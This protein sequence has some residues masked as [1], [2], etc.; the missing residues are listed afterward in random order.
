VRLNRSF[1]LLLFGIGLYASALDAQIL[2]TLSTTSNSLSAGQSATLTAVCTA[3][4]GNTGVTWSVTPSLGTLGVG[5][6]L[7]GSSITTTNNYAAP[8]VVT[9]RQTVTITAR[10]IQDPTKF[11]SVNIQLNPASIVV[12]PSTVTLNPG[13]SQQFTATGG[14]AG[15]VWSISPSTGSIDHNGVYT[16]PPTVSASTN[17][18]VTATSSADSS[19]FGTARITLTQTQTVSVAIS[20]TSVSLTQGQTQQFTATVSNASSSAVIWSFTPQA[21]TLD[22]NG[23]YTA[24]S[25]ITATSTIRVTA[26]AAADASKSASA[27][28]TLTSVIDVGSGAPTGALQNQFIGAF[29]RN[30]FANLVSLPPLGAVKRL[31]TTGYVQ[32]F[33]D[34][35]KTGAKLALATLSPSAPQGPD[36]TNSIAQL[37]ADLYA[38]YTTVGATTAGLPLYDTLNCPAFDGNSC[39][40][41]IFDKGYALFAYHSPLATGQNFTIRN[42]FYTEWTARLGITGPGRPVDVETAVTASTKTTATVQSFVNGAIYVI[43]SGVNNAKA[44][45]VLSP[46][47]DVYIATGGPA[48]SLGLPIT[49]EIT[50]S[51]G[52]HRQTFEGG[53]LEYTPG[54]GGPSQRLPVASVAIAGASTGVPVA[55]NLGDM[56]TLTAT[57]TAAN[58]SALTDRPVSWSTS[59][60]KVVSIEAAGSK[61]VLH[62]TGGG[63]AAVTATSEGVLSPKINLIVIAPCCQVGDGAPANVQRSFQDALTRNRIT[64]QIPVAGPAARVSN[65]YVQVI[66][67]SDGSTYWLAQSDQVGSAFVVGG[68]I[69]QAYDALGGPAGTLGYPLSDRSAGGTQRFENGAALAGNPVR[70]VN[71]GVLAKWALLGYEAGSAGAPT[72]DAA[73]FSTFGANAGSSQAFS[74]ATLYAASAG[75]RAGQAYSVSGAI[76]A[77]YTALGGASGNF[78]MPT[79]DEFV[80]GG[81]HQQNFEGGN[82]TWAPG[83][84]DAVEHAALKAPGVVASPPTVAAGGRARLALVGFPNASTLKVSVTGQQDFTVATTNGSYSWDM[85]FPLTTRSAVLTVTAL[86]PKSGTTA[87]GTLTI[88]GYNDNRV[89]LAR[90]Q[91]D[92]QTGAPGALLPLSLRVAVRDAA[93]DPVTGATVSFAASSGSLLAAS[94]VTDG[95]GIAETL[96]RLPAQ[97]TVTLVTAEAPGVA[98]APVTFA[99]RS[100]ATSL[101]N[102]PKLQQAGRTAIGNG[103]ATIGQ[104]GALL[105]A[106]AS[107]LRYHQNRSELPGPNGSADPAALNTFLK[108]YCAPD[109]SGKL[110]CDG[111][112]S[113][114]DSGEQVVNLWR[115]AEFTGGA[116]VEI[117]AP[118]TN[119]I[120]DLVAGG[121]PVLLSLGLSRNGAVA[122]G[123]FVVAI[124]IAAD[125]SIAIQDPSPV[126]ARVSLK[127]Y[128]GGFTANG[129]IWKAEVRGVAQFALNSP[130]AT[131]FLA[132]AISQPPGGVEP[133]A[134][135]VSS[136][137]GWCGRPIDLLDA[138]DPAAAGN[139]GLMSRILG[140]DGAQ[141]VYQLQVG[142]GQAFRAVV[143]DLAAGGAM[144]DISGA[145][146]SSY[147]LTRPKLNLT[148]AS[149]DVAVQAGGIVGAATFTPGIAPGGAASIF[150]SGLSGAGKNTMLDL[151]GTS[152]RVIFATPFQLNAEVPPGTTPGAHTLH[153]QS[154]YGTAAQTVT[155]SAVAPGIFMVGNPP[156][157]A[158]TNAAGGL[159]VP[160]NPLARGQTV[161]VWA[162]GLGAVTA[163]GNL[164]VT[165][166]T[167]T[168]VVGGVE[169]PVQFAG[170]APGFL[171]LGLYQ[172]NVLIP[173]STPPG[174]NVPFALKIEGQLSNAVSLAIQ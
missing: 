102:F 157:A 135:S 165:S 83:S 95:N 119:A 11:A 174:L 35:L 20:P 113:N 143:D 163:S 2:V 45:T 167:V 70:L 82:I 49:Q 39:T 24:P 118:T 56:L 121:S 105:T 51:S 55:L 53:I 172:V 67:G 37:Y 86:E 42:T 77:R 153:I 19:V 3:N 1:L 71:A 58:G 26:T 111:F 12:S 68:L 147:K 161:T 65:G 90:V 23:L 7:N 22:A 66:Q 15:Y 123:H 93:G 8:D 25:L 159:V 166:S 61:A 154:A 89:A 99:V 30:G 44:F 54:G 48:S 149:Q 59:N 72:G 173:T 80:T 47:Y 168:A 38:Y 124:G 14:G 142:S 104:K 52:V 158:V 109:A 162:T 69:L 146:A 6:N 34:T 84:S 78:G 171:G 43:S 76:L 108:N 107:I 101:A 127:D 29:F 137:A 10:S 100:M 128:L 17:V 122:G 160:S 50:L 164:S 75:P 169:L 91:G 170:L 97:E 98:S 60:S 28:V 116:D 131:R 62:A 16:A 106:V 92:N 74:G 120:A 148:I 46:I 117:F 73:A 87:S 96:V 36:T 140:C 32:E 155:V 81:V 130:V 64:P 5:N 126:F 4:S 27:T 136:P 110:N 152:M 33:N 85:F 139:T 40:Y 63:L 94:A 18:T 134:L 41:D 156:V 144:T 145:A 150:G 129:D 151:D 138:V 133:M 88:K 141:S 57:P 125:G 112:L 31:G 132:A 114:P 103:T 79:S 13:A 21:G 115:A 9:V